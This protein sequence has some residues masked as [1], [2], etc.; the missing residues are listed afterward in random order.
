MR[1]RVRMCERVCV[2]LHTKYKSILKYC[3]V[4]ERARLSNFPTA[5]TKTYFHECNYIYICLCECDS[6]GAFFLHNTVHISIFSRLCRVLS[7]LFQYIW[8]RL[9]LW[10]ERFEWLYVNVKA[11]APDFIDFSHRIFYTNNKYIQ[12]QT[13]L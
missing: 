3:T 4:R 8:S 9:K 13:Y 6:V 2:L 11:V 1:V 5:T 12:R 7:F 10:C